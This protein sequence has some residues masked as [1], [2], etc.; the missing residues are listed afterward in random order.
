[1]IALLRTFVLAAHRPVLA[2][3]PAWQQRSVLESHR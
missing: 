3:V 2:V 1:M